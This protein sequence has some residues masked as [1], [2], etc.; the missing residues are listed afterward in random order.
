MAGDEH[1]GAGREGHERA[2][3]AAVTIR[4]PFE[5]T[6]PLA[7]SPCQAGAEQELNWRDKLFVKVQVRTFC[8][9]P[10]D[11]GRKLDRARD[12]ILEA[13]AQAEHPIL[14]G[15]DRSLWRADLYLEATKDVPGA[16]M[17][18]LSG[19]FLAKVFEGPQR[20]A[21]RWM[22]E[23]ERLASARG[24]RIEQLFQGFTTCPGCAKG[25]AQNCVV[26]YAKLE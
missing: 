9:L 21:Q 7:P 5:S 22:E 17:V 26:L 15:D 2:R 16:E 6:Q 10:L 19:R 8:H 20:H 18:R 24:E 14:L 11:L 12:S 25:Y 13:G 4:T 3:A 23:M 1:A